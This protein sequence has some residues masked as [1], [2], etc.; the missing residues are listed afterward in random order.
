M[1]KVVR[2]V[3]MFQADDGSMHTTKKGAERCNALIALSEW[4]EDNRIYGGPV[5]CSIGWYDLVDWVRS[6]GT[7]QVMKLFKTVTEDIKREK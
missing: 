6:T 7:E 1:A 4:Y 3:T 2:E 5:G